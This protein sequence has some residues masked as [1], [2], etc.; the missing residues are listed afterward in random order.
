[1]R[2]AL[3]TGSHAHGRGSGLRVDRIRSSTASVGV[4]G[5]VTHFFNMR[6]E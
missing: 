3:G 5:H 1:M 6:R 4:Q 2:L